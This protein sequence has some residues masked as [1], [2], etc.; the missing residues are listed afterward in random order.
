VT[1]KQI[2]FWTAA[3]AL[4]AVFSVLLSG[5]VEDAVIL[6][7]VKFFWLLKGYYGSL[8]QVISWG[9]LLVLLVVIAVFSLRGGTPGLY[10]RREQVDELPG[11][12]GQLAFWIRRS[13][14]GPYP[15]W[16]LARTLAELALDL[17]RGRGADAERGGQLT[18]P[19]WE[20]PENTQA[21]LETAMRTTPA[22]FSRQLEQAEV[23][24][25]P[26][27]ESVIEY[28]ESYA[29]TAND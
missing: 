19:G 5:A 15:R 18:G 25:D 1:K 16:Y 17:L 9:A 10:A 7:V 2:L 26:E 11:E 22:T 4:L 14:H 3:L 24:R 27:A 23:D 20:P 21:Y 12:V 6:P 29:E 13:K 8:D 28:L